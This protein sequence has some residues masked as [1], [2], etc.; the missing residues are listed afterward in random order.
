MSTVV[1]QMIASVQP[2]AATAL[3]FSTQL[4]VF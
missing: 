1:V 2:R 4:P 3:S